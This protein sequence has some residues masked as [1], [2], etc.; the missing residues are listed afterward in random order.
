MPS[1]CDQNYGQALEKMLKRESFGKPIEIYYYEKLS[2]LNQCD[3]S[4][5]RADDCIVHSITDRTMKSSARALCCSQ[6]DQLL[7]FL[8][9]NKE[10]LLPDRSNNFT[11]NKTWPVNNTIVQNKNNFKVKPGTTRCSTFHVY[12]TRLDPQDCV[13][14]SFASRV[15]LFN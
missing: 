10:P 15:Q 2:L 9:S 8:M 4:G 5:K 1:P 3:I 12:V 14:V 13:M 11:K 7:Q 6:P